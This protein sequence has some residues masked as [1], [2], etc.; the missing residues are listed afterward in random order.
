MWGND[1]NR[2]G[3]LAEGEQGMHAPWRDGGLHGWGT[4]AGIVLY[5][6]AGRM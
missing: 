1:V 4:G 6:Q 5:V 2:E 3:K